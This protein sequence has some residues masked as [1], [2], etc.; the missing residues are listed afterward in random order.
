MSPVLDQRELRGTGMGIA[1]ESGKQILKEGIGEYQGIVSLSFKCCLS[2]APHCSGCFEWVQK[3]ENRVSGCPEGGAVGIWWPEETFNTNHF[4]RLNLNFEP[5]DLG[6]TKLHLIKRMVHILVRKL[7]V[8][9]KK[10]FLSSRNSDV[11][12]KT[13]HPHLIV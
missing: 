1:P 7:N 11:S 8:V 9:F 2:W 13:G 4:Y 10:W 6:I 3:R 5:C 12:G